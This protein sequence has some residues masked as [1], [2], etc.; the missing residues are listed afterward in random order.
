MEHGTLI[1]NLRQERNLTQIQLSIG[2]TS[3]TTLSSFENSGKKITFSNLIMYLDRM[4]I[5]LEEYEFLYREKE[6]NNKRASA[7]LLSKSFTQQF[8][9]ETANNFLNSFKKTNDFF[10]Y[11]LYAQYYLVVSFKENALNNDEIQ[12]I[13]E[14]VKNYLN[15]IYTWGRFELVLFTNCLFLFDN[16]YIWFHFNESVKQMK[17]YIDSTNYSHDL[18]KFLINGVQL[19]YERKDNTNFKLFFDELCQVA[20]NYN[21]LKAKL[22]IRIFHLLKSEHEN[23]LVEKENLIQTLT[24][25]DEVEWIQYINKYL[26]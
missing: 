25:L 16:R 14:N 22:I 12:N 1:K 21:E 13:A 17:I 7:N 20:A 24:Y 4:N 9:Q 19:S 15:S 26:E 18:L 8:Q 23:L 2:I 6:M 10:Y 5:S 11:S 3:R